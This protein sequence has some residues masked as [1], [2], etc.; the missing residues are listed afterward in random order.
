MR[1][2]LAL[3]G[4][5]QFVGAGLLISGHVLVGI[6]ILAMSHFLFLYGSLVPCSQLFGPVQ[7]RLPD[8][9]PD[10]WIT[11]DDGPDPRTTPQLLAALQNHR[12][13][14]TFFLIGERVVRHPE[15][16]REIHRAG[17]SIGNHTFTHPAGRFWCISPGAVKNEIARCDEAILNI[18][19]RSPTLFRSPAGHSNPFTR[20]AATMA[21]KTLVAWSARGFDGV[22]TPKDQV[23]ASIQKNLSPGAI[24]VIHEAYDINKRGYSPVEILDGIMSSYSTR[25][26]K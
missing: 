6:G 18:T 12:I 20:R 5:A 2:S 1:L 25:E 11:I 26:Q 4:A 17:H 23:I 3:L 13:K 15:L 16:V 22:H 21:G 7:C 14:A 9:S 24:I 19:G 8:D 10:V